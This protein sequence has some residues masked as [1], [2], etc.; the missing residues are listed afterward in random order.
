MYTF[1]D[2]TEVSEDNT[3][4]SEALKINGEYI[5][6]QI[7]GY[8]TLYVSGRESLAPEL[9]TIEPGSRD[10]A[11]LNYKRYP[12]RTITVGYQL[13]AATSENFRK[14]YNLLLNIL[15]VQ[16]SE[17]IFADEPDKYFA[18][19][20]TSMSDIE[21]G[22]NC[23]TA[24]FEFTCLDP[25]KRSVSEYE[26]EPASDGNYFAV[27]YNGNYK[28][29]PTFEVDFYTDESGT[30]NDNGRCGYVAL[31]DDDEHILQFGN[32]DELSEEEVE[33]VEKETN[34]YS[35]PTTKVLLN[36]SFKKS[37]T[38]NNLKSKYTTN[39]GTIY[40]TSTQT[41]SLGNSKSNSE[42][43]YL[44]AT[45]FGSGDRFHGPTATYTL[46]ETATDFQFDYAQKM[47]V[48]STKDGKK[49]CGAFQMILSDE[50]GGIVAGVDIFKSGDG[51]K[52]KYRMI[53][54][55]KVQKEAEIDLS[56]HNKYFGSNRAADKKKK[57]KEIKTAKSSSIVKK[58]AKISFNLGG[59]KQSFTINSVKSKSVKK[60]TVMFSQKGKSSSLKYNGLYSMK[61]VKNYSKQVT[62]T[63]DKI[64][65]EYHDVQNKFNANDVFIIDCSSAT[66]KLN[67]LDRPDLGALGNDWE[68][69]CLQQGMNQIGFGYSDWV[70][71]TYAPRFK[72]RYREVFL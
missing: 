37:G 56:L 41:G 33:V 64:V 5:E 9:T 69:L 46:S 20:Y 72:L 29:Y 49:Q 31:F 57:I 21:P 2:T 44:T 67:E 27:Q 17:L 66:A 48:D 61:L 60:I 25:F 68:E 63:I 58:G 32:P 7:T 11:V 52:G 6:N 50:S 38:W 62:E 43:Y 71:S 1:T 47:C 28:S 39:K 19:T 42:Q 70:E 18:G 23:V 3:L 12:T 4:P 54:D 35:V 10:G 24:E 34:T 65:T 22:R 40:K 55:G 30:E 51:T 15:S 13:L 16:D 45:G 14:A 26:V 53:V 36:H 59:I 8:R